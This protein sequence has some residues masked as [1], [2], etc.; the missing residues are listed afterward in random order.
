MPEKEKPQNTDGWK[1]DSPI[2]AGMDYDFA[3]M[4][5]LINSGLLTAKDNVMPPGHSEWVPADRVAQLSEVIK[6]KE[7][8]VRKAEQ[9]GL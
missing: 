7:E 9:R 3:G 1:V 5:G 8:A 2:C 6:K 4:V